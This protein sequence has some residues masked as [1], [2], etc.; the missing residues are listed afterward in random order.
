MD[1]AQMALQRDLAIRCQKRRQIRFAEHLSQLHVHETAD[2]QD[3]YVVR[4]AL[5]G[6]RAARAE[7]AE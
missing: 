3:R 7:L 5:E 1:R 4:S 6:V 2:L